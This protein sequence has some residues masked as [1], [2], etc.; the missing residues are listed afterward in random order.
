VVNLKCIANISDLC[1]PFR[2]CIVKLQVIMFCTWSNFLFAN[3]EIYINVTADL[4]FCFVFVFYL[5][6]LKGKNEI[7]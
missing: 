4:F 5:S 1:C 6:T 2:N 7:H 3:S